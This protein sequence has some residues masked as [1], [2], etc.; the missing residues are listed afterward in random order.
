[1]YTCQNK[2]LNK[3]KSCISIKMLLK[4]FQS[5]LYDIMFSIV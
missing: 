4:E 3:K 5:W 1:M 2:A